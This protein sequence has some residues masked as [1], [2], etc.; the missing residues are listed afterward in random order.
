M[1]F[2]TVN[3]DLRFA[4]TCCAGGKFCPTL[5]RPHVPLHSLD[6]NG[7]RASQVAA[8]LPRP[9]VAVLVAAMKTAVVRNHA[10]KLREQVIM[11]SA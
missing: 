2:L 4:L 5:G 11:G 3:V 1:R 10:D 8:T 7:V 9:L 6:R